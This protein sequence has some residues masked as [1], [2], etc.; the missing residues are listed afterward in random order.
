M[1]GDF[2]RWQEQLR[3]AIYQWE[4]SGKDP[5]GLLRG[6]PLAIAQDWEQKRLDELSARE[7][8]FIR[9]SQLLRDREIN[10]KRTLREERS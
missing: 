7:R 4:S 1:D 2:R 3:A 8:N 10:N 6:G 5:G 9:S